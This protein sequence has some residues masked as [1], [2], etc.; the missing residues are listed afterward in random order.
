MHQAQFIISNFTCGVFS[1]LFC[2][3]ALCFGY[4]GGKRAF[5][6]IDSFFSA[7]WI[8]FLWHTHT[9]TQGGVSLIIFVLMYCVIGK[10]QQPEILEE[11]SSKACFGLCRDETRHRHLMHRAHA[12]ISLSRSANHIRCS[13][14]LSLSRMAAKRKATNYKSNTEKKEPYHCQSVSANCTITFT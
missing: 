9:H 1:L 4:V 3:V 6:H 12:H 7:F 14:S 8:P 2:V 13:L 11:P 10:K 5:S